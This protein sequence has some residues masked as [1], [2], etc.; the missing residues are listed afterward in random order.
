[1][2]LDLTQPT[3][4]GPDPE[5]TTPKPRRPKAGTVFRTCVLARTCH[6]CELNRATEYELGMIPVRPKLAD[7]VM[8]TTGGDNRVEQ[9]FLCTTHGSARGWKGR[10]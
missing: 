3:L 5:P 6:D 9:V 7:V 8:E 1:M 4:F 10:A 2:S